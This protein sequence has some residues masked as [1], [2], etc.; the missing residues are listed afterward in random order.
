MT[1]KQSM[2]AKI[3]KLHD[4]NALVNSFA[5]AAMHEIEILKMVKHPAIVSYYGCFRDKLD[6]WILMGIERCSLRL[7]DILQP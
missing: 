4:E 2:A 5:E 6:M 1:T 3:L 7:A